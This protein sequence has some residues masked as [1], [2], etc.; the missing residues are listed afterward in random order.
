MISSNPLDT[1][2]PEYITAPQAAKLTGFS[3]RALESMRA[4]RTGPA[5]VK[6]GMAKNS[7]IR[8]R[9]KDIHNWMNQHKQQMD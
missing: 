1:I 9:L 8:Y 7:P 5:Y 2:V 3:L 4:K 6:V